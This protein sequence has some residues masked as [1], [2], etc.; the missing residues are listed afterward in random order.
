MQFLKKNY[1]K[2]LLAAVIIAALGV[3]AF[4]PI[5]VPFLDRLSGGVSNRTPG[6]DSA[7]TGLEIDKKRTSDRRYFR[8][9]RLSARV[10]WRNPKQNAMGC[11]PRLWLA[12]Y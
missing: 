3:V 11:S 12:C 9:W 10:N 4:L 6:P 2:V 8:R 1:E 5:L 7:P